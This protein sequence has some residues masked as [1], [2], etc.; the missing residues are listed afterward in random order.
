MGRSR[1]RDA[2]AI[3]GVDTSATQKLLLSAT[4]LVRLSLHGIPHSGYI[5]PEAMVALLS[6]LA[7]LNTLSLGFKSPQSR[8]DRESRCLPPLKCSILPALDYFY[9]NGVT[10]YLEELVT[11]VDTP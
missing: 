10:G 6:M 8:P 5:S 2:G 3:P 1:G 9:F 4:H 11:H 7:S